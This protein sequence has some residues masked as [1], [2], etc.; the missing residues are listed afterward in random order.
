MFG[1]AYF[2]L[3]RVT[4][5]AWRAPVLISAHYVATVLGLVALI[6][7]LFAAGWQQGL[8]LNDA[9]VPFADITK[10][11]IPWLT[12]RSVALMLLSVGHVA[13]LINCA[14]IA[15]PI[16]LSGTAAAAGNNPPE[17]EAHKA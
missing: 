13:F 8:L 2:I 5:Q 17:L 16:F 1:A 10:T 15:C 7:G 11:L 6:V 14:W 12:F 3:P 4:G 9:T